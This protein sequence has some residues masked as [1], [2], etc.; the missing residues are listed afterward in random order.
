MSCDPS[1]WGSQEAHWSPQRSSQRRVFSPNAHRSQEGRK[2]VKEM[3]RTR[4]PGEDQLHLSGVM[5]KLDAVWWYGLKFIKLKI[6]ICVPYTHVH[7]WNVLKA[8]HE[9]ENMDAPWMEGWTLLWAGR[10]PGH[11]KKEKLGTCEMIIILLCQL[12]MRRIKI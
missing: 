2:W 7:M 12:Y 3:E 9:V 11:T 8:V 10:K 5:E 4:V 6:S 1:V